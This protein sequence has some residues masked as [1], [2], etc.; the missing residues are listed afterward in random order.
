MTTHP[1]DP[2]NKRL[3]FVTG[4][5]GGVG[6]SFTARTLVQHHLDT[7][8]ACHAYD[9]DPVNPSLHQYYPDHTIRL[10]LEEPGALD[11][12]RNDLEFNQLL[13][14]DCAARSLHELDGWFR[15]LGL[16]RQRHDLHLG[17]TFVF[18]IT[19]DK[20]CTA[21]MSESLDRFG[22]EADYLVVKNLK[23]GKDFSIYENSKLRKRLLEEYQGKEITLPPLLERTVVLLDRHDL[24]FNRAMVDDRVTVADRSRVRGFLDQAYAELDTVRD[25]LIV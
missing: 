23:M 1:S 13:L 17:I 18:V 15:E 6:K 2:L 4:D 21:I 25:R 3:V 7:N 10:N 20:S 24:G 8:Q 12:I 14:V 22:H 11:Q 9:I 5:K 16:L 19:P